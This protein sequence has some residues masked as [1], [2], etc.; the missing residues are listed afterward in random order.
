MIRCEDCGKTNEKHYEENVL[1]RPWREAYLC[2]TCWLQ[3]R[4]KERVLGAST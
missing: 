2:L 4:T 3:R 1:W